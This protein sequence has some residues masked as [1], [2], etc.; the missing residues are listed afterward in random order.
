MKDKET[1]TTEISFA[2][3]DLDKLYAAVKLIDTEL[4]L[5]ILEIKDCYGFN[6]VLNG[7]ILVTFISYA[8]TSKNDLGMALY[9]LGYE[10]NKNYY[11]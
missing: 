3:K 2:K 8:K 4:G 7:Y 1:L 6:N 10:M 5:Q 11:L 9:M